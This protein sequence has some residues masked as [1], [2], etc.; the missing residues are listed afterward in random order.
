MPRGNAYKVETRVCSGCEKAQLFEYFEAQIGD[1][2]FYH[3]R[4]DEATR[5]NKY[6][7]EFKPQIP[8]HQGY[9]GSNTNEGDWFRTYSQLLLTLRADNLS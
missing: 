9:L 2:F 3:F 7:G 8:E 4:W 6:C 5:S 1:D